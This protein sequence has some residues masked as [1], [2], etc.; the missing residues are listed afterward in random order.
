MQYLLTVRGMPS[1]LLTPPQA[2]RVASCLPEWMSPLRFPLHQRLQSETTARKPTRREKRNATR[3]REL[4]PVVTND[5]SKTPAANVAASDVREPRKKPRHQRGMPVVEISSVSLPSSDPPRTAPP[6]SDSDSGSGEGDDS[7]AVN[8]V[9]Q[10]GDEASDPDDVGGSDKGEES[11][12]HQ[13]AVA[14]S[15]YGVDDE[16]GTPLMGSSSSSVGSIPWSAPLTQ[17]LHEQAMAGHTT[18][19]T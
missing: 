6:S 16:A 3:A 9:T 2:T 18:G 13:A 10:A 7:R 11:D 15:S 14:A 12:D 1:I 4:P 17:A 8:P 19:R 5:T